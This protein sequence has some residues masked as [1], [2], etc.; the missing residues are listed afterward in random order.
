MA[1]P[2]SASSSFRAPTASTTRSL[3][4]ERLG[5]DARLV[6]HTETSLRGLE[7]W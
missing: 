3:A 7:R 6:F 1:A 5:A 4:L 2:A